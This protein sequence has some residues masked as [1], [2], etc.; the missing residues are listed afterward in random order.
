MYKSIAW[1][2]TIRETSI[3]VTKAHPKHVL[4]W[5]TFVLEV[6]EVGVTGIFS[7]D[8]DMLDNTAAEPRHVSHLERKNFLIDSEKESHCSG[9]RC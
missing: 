4:G 9:P 6:S 8:N 2:L 3:N 5:G 1:V 7:K